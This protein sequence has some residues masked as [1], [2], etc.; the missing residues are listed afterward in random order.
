MLSLAIRGA[1][2]LQGTVSDAQPAGGPVRAG[3]DSHRWVL[4]LCYAAFGFG[5]IIPATFL[6]AMAREAIS[7][8]QLFGWAW[9]VFG[10][11]A[12]AS[13]FYAGSFANQRNVWMIAALI[14]ALGVVAPLMMPGLWGILVAATLVGGTFMVMTMAGMQ[15][16]RRV[17]AERARPLMAAMTAGFAFGQIAGPLCVGYK[18]GVTHALIAAA[19][20][21]VLSAAAL[22]FHGEKT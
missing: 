7:D 4:I 1:P 17:A 11:A 3:A 15:E 21:L 20:L 10:A 22:Y 16:A 19:A 6:P 14:M 13:T 9:P 8:P 5:Y 12:A 2:H 18:S